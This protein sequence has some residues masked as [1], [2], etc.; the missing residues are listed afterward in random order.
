MT[1]RCPTVDELD[2]ARR[3]ADEAPKGQRIKARLAF[4]NKKHATLRSFVKGQRKAEKA[5][6]S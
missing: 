3:W 6:W 2:A 5:V 4:S 1:V